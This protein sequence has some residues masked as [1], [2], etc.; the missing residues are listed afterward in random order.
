MDYLT[1]AIFSLRPSAQFSFI[2][3]D[4]ST[5]KW[6]VL[7]GNAPT[8]AEIDAE[9]KAIKIAETQAIIDAENAKAAAQ[10]KLEALGLTT[11]DLK[12]LGL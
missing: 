11:N 8:Q 2:N 4:Y 12:A 7:D 1:K 9:I 5:I 10:A 3:E 6:D